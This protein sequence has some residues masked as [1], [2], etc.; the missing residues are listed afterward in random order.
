M[1]ENAR[2]DHDIELTVFLRRQMANIVLHE[3]D[4]RKIQFLLG[5]IA[6]GDAHRTAFNADGLRPMQGEFDG[7]VALETGEVQHPAFRQWL[8]HRILGYLHQATQAI[9]HSWGASI[10]TVRE[11]DRH[12]GP[13]AMRLDESLRVFADRRGHSRM[14]L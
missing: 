11:P 3:R 12:R 4:A 2:A 8:V 13:A 9:I 6:L 5:V 7:V 1:I 10:R 14:G